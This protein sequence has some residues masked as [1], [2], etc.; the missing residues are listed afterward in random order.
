[1][2]LSSVSRARWRFAGELGR[3]IQKNVDAWI[4]RAPEANPGM[5]DMFRRRERAH[6]FPDHTPW[7]GEFAGKYLISAVQA[8]KLSPTV[9]LRTHVARF[10]ADLIATQA[11]D[12]YL[13]PWPKDRRLKGDCDLWGHYHCMLGLLMWADETG[14][15]KAYESVL[16][17]ADC[18]CTMY[19]DQGRRPIEAGNPC[20][21]LSV[22]HIVAE[23][24][25]RTGNQR[26]QMLAQRI[27]EDLAR[28]GDWLNRGVSGE[29]YWKLPGSGARWE[30][31][32]I[33]QG[34]LVLWQATGETRYRTAV[35]NLWRSIRDNDRH[36]SGAFSTNE[37]AMGTTF[38][39]GSIETCCSVAWM[40]LSIDV[41]RLT[42][43]PTVADEVELT[44]WNQA[45]AAQHPSGSWCT[46]DTPLN[47]VR[48]PSYHQISFQY[49]PG[50]PELN[51]CSVNSPR[52]LGMLTDWAVMRRGKTVVIQFYGPCRVEVP[53]GEGRSLRVEQQTR[54]P[55]DGTVRIGLDA[56]E[57][58]VPVEFRIPGWSRSTTVRVNGK[59]PAIVAR[60]GSYLR[61]SR[62]WKKGDEVA[63]RFEMTPRVVY[64]QGPDR[65][66][67]VAIHWGPL[68][69]ALDSGFNPIDV[70]DAGPLDMRS[71]RLE[72]LSS[73]DVDA[74]TRGLPYPPMGLW[75]TTTE[76]GRWILLCDFASAG[77]RGTEYAAW[78][79]ASHVPPPQV[80]LLLP[81]PGMAGKPG[82]ILF[83]WTD[84]GDPDV[85]YELAIARDPAFRDVVLLVSDIR[86]PRVV[87]R[88]GLDA[89]GTYYWKVRSRNSLGA[90]DS[91]GGPSRFVIRADAGNT[92]P[93]VRED[94]CLLDAPLAGVAEPV[95]G[96][97]TLQSGVSPCEGPDGAPGGAL[98]FDG[99]H[100]GLRYRLP[101]FP[102]EAYTF[103]AW[104]RPDK[105][106]QG[107]GQIVSAWCRGMDDPLRLS[108]ENGD[109][110]ARMEAGSAYRTAGAKVEA[111]R[112]VA[113]GVVKRGGSLILYLDGR[114]IA[115][116]DVP[117][118][119]TTMAS[120]LGIGF[121]P[122]FHGGERFIGAIA[123]VRLYD[124]ALSGNEIAEAARLR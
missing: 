7:A 72:V 26:L 112:W 28:D 108:V 123:R 118:H 18:I 113:V 43:D 80:K 84:A 19:V 58:D 90:A 30:A 32:H 64:G 60:P 92:F 15:R 69:L 42:G 67:M 3:R 56:D 104:V 31:L 13:G 120:E 34:L 100:S 121:N 119:P 62:R 83:V 95:F 35:L 25:R 93:S 122:F 38:A 16:K 65:G 33:L 102:S 99:Q 70:G 8:Y 49:R 76:T 114:E 45:L 17:A 27:V 111:G 103:V 124:R 115:S 98:L 53:L 105:P 78:L 77:A 71:C 2:A 87:I 59:E 47:G 101:Y 24:Y 55:V 4:L 82:P 41:L 75:R 22:L 96:V 5:L 44:L 97:L 39:K 57:R 89:E 61:L 9:Q 110:S 109:I 79:R 23:L 21:N 54:Y 40:A 66:G 6:P 37:Q 94:G 117:E 86:E 63:L 11:P 73:K 50:T 46:Y 88:S 36:P 10:V 106:G 85:R 12:G 68:L 51:C 20:F 48:A 29:P 81:E 14:E 91:R 74:V 52:T 116:C 107:M 1:M